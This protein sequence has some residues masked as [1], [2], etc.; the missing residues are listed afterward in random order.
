MVSGVGGKEAEFI[1]ENYLGEDGERV[2]EGAVRLVA[3]G[4]FVLAGEEGEIPAGYVFKP[5]DAGVVVVGII[6]G[7][8]VVSQREKI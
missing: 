3:E 7:I 1:M 8:A 4:R 6:P 5:F 2:G